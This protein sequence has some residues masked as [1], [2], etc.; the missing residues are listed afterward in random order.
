MTAGKIADR[1]TILTVVAFDPP[2]VEDREIESTV[3]G[4]LHPAG[5]ARLHRTTRDIHPNVDTLHKVTGDLLIV[6]F[7][8]NSSSLPMR[9]MIYAHQFLQNGFCGTVLRMGFTGE[10][11]LHR[12]CRVV[13]HPEQTFEVAKQKI[14]AFIG[15]D[16]AGKADGQY[17]RRE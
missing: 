8:K 7:D 10:D 12:S 6:I 3:H 13:N 4:G 14:P 11:K 5:A 16:T 15:R 2:A 9:L 1:K 17:I